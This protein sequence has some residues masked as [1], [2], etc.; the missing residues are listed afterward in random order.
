MTKLFNVEEKLRELEEQKNRFFQ[1]LLILE[2]K[3]EKHTRTIG[4]HNTD[5]PPKPDLQAPED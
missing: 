2:A 5:K 4:L 3:F 1:R